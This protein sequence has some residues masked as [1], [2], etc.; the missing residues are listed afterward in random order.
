MTMTADL[1][2]MVPRMPPLSR[3]AIEAVADQLLA[4]VA[5]EM[6]TAA[7]P[8]D[9]V[10]LVDVTLPKF[11][12][13]FYPA[14]AVELED[15]E[16]ATDPEGENETIVLLNVDLFED[17]YIGG[18]YAYRARATVAHEL[19]HVILHVPVVRRRLRSPLGAAL[20]NRVRRDQVKA[21]EDPEWQAWA[22]AGCLLMPRRA[23]MQLKTNSVAA[24]AEH[25]GVSEAMARS[26]LRRFKLE[27]RFDAA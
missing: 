9:V 26:H 23:L 6:L 7:M 2:E 25:F 3:Y 20:L 19:G 12:V 8:L 18:R 13:H 22:L 17:L 14:S 15:R 24:V 4:L 5:P 21:Y 1:L 10:K 16:A 11:G 27:G